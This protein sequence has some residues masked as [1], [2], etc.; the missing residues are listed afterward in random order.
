MPCVARCDVDSTHVTSGYGRPDPRGLEKVDCQATMHEPQ[1]D[2]ATTTALGA[3]FATPLP[4]PSPTRPQGPNI[5]ACF[6]TRQ[7]YIGK[8]LSIVRAITIVRICNTVGRPGI[9]PG[10]AV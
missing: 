4:H 8:E 5:F 6:G 3:K 1:L 10:A 2:H 7:P 9:L